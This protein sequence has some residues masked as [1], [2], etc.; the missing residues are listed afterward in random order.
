MVDLTYNPV[1]PSWTSISKRLRLSSVVSMFEK[2]GTIQGTGTHQT[3]VTNNDSNAEILAGDPATSTLTNKSITT[4]AIVFSEN[5]TTVDSFAASTTT[6][7]ECYDPSEPQNI[8]DVLPM[9]QILVTEMNVSN[10][11]PSCPIKDSADLQINL[12]LGEDVHNFSSE[13]C[14]QNGKIEAEL[15]F[16]G[17][18]YSD[19][20]AD[21]HTSAVELPTHDC[22]DTAACNSIEQSTEYVSTEDLLRSRSLSL[23]RLNQ[24][25]N[26]TR[27]L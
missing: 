7:Q 12:D 19:D 13:A 9:D 2:L 11:P 26:L 1:S 25:L 10:T 3:N 6:E 14:T 23:N 18:D 5:D 16:N 21:G 20:C 27:S 8:P 24:N 17:H 22:I 15:S 4:T